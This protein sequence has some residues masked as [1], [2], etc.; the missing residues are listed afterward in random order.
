M[1]DYGHFVDG[2]Q[3]PGT[4]GRFS[5]VYDPAKGEITGRVALASLQELDAAVLSAKRAFVGWSAKPPLT[6]VRVMFKYKELLERNLSRLAEL[7]S[8]EHGK[9]LADAAGEV[10][11]G[12]EVV[13][14]AC[15]IPHL[16]KGE[17][18]ENVG[19]NVDCYAMRQPLGVCA[20]ITPFNFPAMV[21]MWMFPVAVACGNSFILKPSE[22]DP[23]VPLLLAALLCEAG[24]PEGVMNVVNGDK[25]AV[26]AILAHPDIEA[27]SFVGSTPNMS[28]GPAPPIISGSRRWAAPR[29]ICWCCPTRIWTRPPMR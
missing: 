24:A 16:L 14:F 25:E 7:I 18:S 12:I 10:T 2:K 8:A 17:F 27:V 19:T 22:R 3:I 5:D 20:G 28:I 11:R 29:T 23:A 4:S 1:I 9:T 15:G 26:D 13:E 21:P 6:R